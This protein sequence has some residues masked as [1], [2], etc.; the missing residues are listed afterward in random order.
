MWEQS[1]PGCGEVCD[2]QAVG[3][4]GIRVTQAVGNCRIRVTQAVGKCGI[5]VTQAVGKCGISDPGCGKVWDQWPR[6]WEG[7]GSE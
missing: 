4:C 7:V 3:K 6:L 5:R 1:D 2:P